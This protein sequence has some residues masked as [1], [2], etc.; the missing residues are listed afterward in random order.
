MKISFNLNYH[1][2]WGESLYLCGDLVELGSGDPREALEMSLVSPDLWRVDVEFSQNPPAFDFFFVVKSKE[3]EWRFE[4]GNPHHYKGCDNV[5]EVKI[6][7][8]WQDMPFDK[9]YYSSAFVDGILQ[10]SHRDKE[11]PVYPDT[12]RLKVSAPMVYPDEVLAICGEGNLLG[13]WLPSKS[14]IMNDAEYPDWCA[15][16]PLSECKQPFEY[17]FVVLKKDTREAVAWETVNNRICGFVNE[18]PGSLIFVDGLRFANPRDHWK[19]AGTAIPVFSIRT[20]ED[21]GVGDF[22]DLKEMVDWCVLTGQ[23]ILQVLPINDTTKTNTWVDSYP[24]SANST[25]ALHPMYLRLEKVGIL[26]DS[27][28]MTAYNK[29]AARL[30]N[31]NE[32][33]YE[34]VTKMKAAYLREIFTQDGA[35]T[36]ATEEFKKFFEKNEDWLMP[37]AAWRVL[38]EKYKTPDNNAWGEYSNFEYNKVSKFCDENKEEIEFRYFIQYHLDKQLHEVRDYAHSKGVVL[39]GD[40]PIGISRYS[41]DA[42]QSPRLFNMDCQ[43]GAP[44]DDFSVLGQNWGFPTYNWEEMSK[45]GFL[46]W[47]A[48]FR[49]MAEYFDAYRIDHILGFFRI[50]QIP[51][52]ALHGLL[53]YFN[54]ALPFSPEELRHNYDFWINPEIQTKPL[55]LEW[56]LTDFFGDAVEEAKVKYLDYIGDGKYRLKDYVNTQAKVARYFEQV[57]KNDRN[58]RIAQALMGLIDDVLFIE[59]PYKKGHYHPRIAAQ[60]TYQ[61]RILTDYEKWCFNRLYNDFFY[62]RHNDFWYGKA[63][64]KLPPLINSTGMLCCAED[65]GMIPACVPEVMSRL[66]ILSLEI[67]RMPKDPKLEFGDTWRYP[68]FSVCTTSTHDMGGIRVWWETDRA[69]TQR[70]YNN[71]LHEHGEA[72]YYAEPWI[73]KKILDL[74]LNSPSMFCIIPLADW[75]SA[76][77]KLRRENPYEDQIN[78]PAN[79]THYWRYRMHL[80]VEE[81]LDQ[82]DFNTDMRNAIISSAR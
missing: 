50:W 37:Y 31:L 67:Q 3:K 44:P 53:G 8:S 65:L 18:K 29:E 66:E 73:C 82:K 77:S 9:P 11:L 33:D 28:K 32:V 27:K 20:K 76:D 23:K 30:N 70:F 49:K 80:T 51:L 63:M 54:P 19:G 60:F 35:D 78:E 48:R 42:W 52:N 68:Y 38:C 45:D 47:K 1:T 10:R 6:F 7:S 40:I 39:K 64:W 43:A 59:D 4:W 2:Q 41:A 81:L 75:L 58:T 26:K 71:A 36:L 72:P 5:G 13:N 74:Q 61:F 21:N 34:A 69:V 57:E 12:V 79:P 56:M 24:Y 16:I 17:K 25:F 55:I 22:L 15:N 62:H 14:L 46:W